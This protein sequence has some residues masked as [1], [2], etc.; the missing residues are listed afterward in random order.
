MKTMET[1]APY[2][3]SDDALLN[4]SR[5]ALAPVNGFA[6]LVNPCFLNPE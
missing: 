3:Y 6:G 2:G 5:T 4:A 1:I